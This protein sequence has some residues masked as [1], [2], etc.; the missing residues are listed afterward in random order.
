MLN[1]TA[2]VSLARSP[3]LKAR[4]K[5]KSLNDIHKDFKRKISPLR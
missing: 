5:K 2:N 1:F 3:E 4:K